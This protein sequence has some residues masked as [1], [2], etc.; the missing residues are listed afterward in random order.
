LS[1]VQRGMPPLPE[2]YR[3]RVFAALSDIG[4]PA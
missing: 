3:N 1:E 4:L 2:S